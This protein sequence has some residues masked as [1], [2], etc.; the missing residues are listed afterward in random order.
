MR[1]Q[2]HVASS[3][4]WPRSSITDNIVNK[5]DCN[6]QMLIG[7]Q[8]THSQGNLPTGSSNDMVTILHSSHETGPCSSCEKE[9]RCL[10]FMTMIQ[11]DLHCQLNGA[12][13]LGSVSGN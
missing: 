13:D 2:N 8:R 12:N 5:N 6:S 9:G 7:E 10:S 11:L 1:K 3:S 4:A